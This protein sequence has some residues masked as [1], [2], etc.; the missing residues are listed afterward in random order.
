MQV[1]LYKVEENLL[2]WKI[3][4]I[5]NVR[6]CLGHLNIPLTR[7]DTGRGTGEGW[8]RVRQGH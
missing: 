2:L 4:W 5:V 7:E 3:S 1:L 6:T 8:V